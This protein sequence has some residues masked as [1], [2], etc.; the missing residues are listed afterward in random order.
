M[1]CRGRQLPGRERRR[2]HIDIVNEKREPAEKAFLEFLADTGYPNPDNPDG[3]PTVS[4]LYHDGGEMVLL[5]DILLPYVDGE[6]Q[7]RN[8]YGKDTLYRVDY[9]RAGKAVRTMGVLE[10]K[11]D[12]DFPE[13][14]GGMRNSADAEIQALCL[15]LKHHITLCGLERLAEEEIS[16]QGAD[17][18]QL[19]GVGESSLHQQ[20]NIA[21]YRK[22][23]SY[24]KRFRHILN[25]QTG[26]VLPPFPER[27]PFMAAWY[28]EH[29]GKEAKSHENRKA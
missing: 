2:L 5:R 28:R 4:L 9:L 25:T 27:G 13:R 11:K 1:I 10:E 20:A 17:R 23:L 8:L 6:I 7:R 29:K 21:Y 15:L 26:S 14:L 12:V 24:V 3:I 16:M 19:D 18:G 22:L